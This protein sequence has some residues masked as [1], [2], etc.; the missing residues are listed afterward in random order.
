M[1]C[2]NRPSS[3]QTKVDKPV[4]THAH[5]YRVVF[6]CALLPHTSCVLRRVPLE[7]EGADT[8]GRGTLPK[9]CADPCSTGSAS[10]SRN[11]LDTFLLRG[12]TDVGKLSEVEIGH[13]GTGL[14]PGE[15][16]QGVV[17]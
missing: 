17:G 8:G 2:V 16:V 13:D 4:H 15:W 7:V 11:A 12:L 14:G 1:Y 5:I 3:S 9:M 10:F 6:T